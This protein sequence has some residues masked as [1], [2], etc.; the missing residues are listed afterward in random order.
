MEIVVLIILFVCIL[1]IIAIY[2]CMVRPLIKK[3]KFNEKKD[4]LQV[5]MTEKEMLETCGEPAKTVLIDKNCKLV[6]YVLD[7]WNGFLFGGT[8]RHEITVTI[9]N[10][11]IASVSFSN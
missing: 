1:L 9:K 10:G 4:S 8:K 5:G 2:L 3:S 6:S 11:K 7:E